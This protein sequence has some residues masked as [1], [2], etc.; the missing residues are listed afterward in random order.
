MNRVPGTADIVVD[1]LYYDIDG[2]G[3]NSK[4]M[5]VRYAACLQ[6]IYNVSK[7]HQE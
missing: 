5:V 4:T 7:V 6:Q 3:I 2:R 1:L